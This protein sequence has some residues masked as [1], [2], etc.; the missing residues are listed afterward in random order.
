MMIIKL[1]QLLFS[2]YSLAPEARDEQVCK[3]CKTFRACRL[4]A[5]TSLSIF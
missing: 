1:S 3:T 4:S 5:F 2:I